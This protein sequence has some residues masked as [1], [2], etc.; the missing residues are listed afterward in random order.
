MKESCYNCKFKGLEAGSDI[1]LGDLW[2]AEVLLPGWDDNTGIS[3]VIANTEK[4]KQLLEMIGIEKQIIGIKQIIQYNKN[5]V[6]P[7]R[8]SEVRR[9]F[10][11]YA[12]SYGYGKAILHFFS[13]TRLAKLKRV[14]RYRIKYLYN[15]FTGRNKPLY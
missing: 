15:R 5:I 8:E 11:A 10:F 12:R 6:Q 7:T 3:A 1:T 2:G 4:G 9:Q 14:T 13:E